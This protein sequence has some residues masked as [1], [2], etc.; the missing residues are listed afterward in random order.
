MVGEAMLP[1]IEGPK[2]PLPTQCC[3]SMPLHPCVLEEMPT[4][5]GMTLHDNMP[6]RGKV[7]HGIPNA[8]TLWKV[9]HPRMPT[10]MK[11]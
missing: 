11:E 10:V 5:K 2:Y 6:I 8:S 7:L 4:C 3:G 9:A 1:N